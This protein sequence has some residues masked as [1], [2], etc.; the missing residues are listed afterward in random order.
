M[1]EITEAIKLFGGFVTKVSLNT[2]W[3][4]QSST[5]QISI[6]YEG[7]GP[8]NSNDFSKNF[9]EP[10]TCVG[11]SIGELKFAGIFQ[12]YTH[13]KDINGYTYNIVLESPAKVLDGVQLILDTFQNSGYLGQGNFNNQIKNVWNPFALLENLNYGGIFGGANVNSAG[14]PGYELFS[15]LGPISRNETRVGGKINYGENEY[16]LDVEEVLKVLTSIPNYHMYRIKGPIQSITSALDDFASL[17]MHD[18]IL[19]VEPKNGQITNGIIKDPVIKVMLIDR[20]KPKDGTAIKQIVQNY[21]KEGKLISADIGKELNDA[22]TQKLVLGGP[23]TRYYICYKDMLV[24]IWGRTKGISP[25]YVTSIVLDDGTLYPPDI[26]EVRCAMH[27]FDSWILFQVLRKYKK[28]S[29]PVVDRY[30]DALFTH[31]RLDEFSLGRIATGKFSAVDFIDS[32]LKSAEKRNLVTQGKFVY[33]ELQKIH[34]SIKAAGEEYWGR[35]FGIPLLKE[36]GGQ[37]N[38]V[39]FVTE[40]YQYINSWEVTDSAWWDHGIFVNDIT[41]YDGEG[42]LKSLSSWEFN[43]VDYDYTNLGNGYAFDRNNNIASVVSLEKDIIWD[44]GN[45]YC[46]AEVPAVSIYDQYTTDHNGLAWLLNMYFNYSFDSLS[47][48][49]TL[50]AESGSNLYGI[51]PARVTPNYIT[52]P[53]VSTRYRYGPWWN[54]KANNG[55]AEVVIEESLSPEV[56]GGVYNMNSVG[57]TYAVVINAEISGRETGS[58]QT[59]GLPESNIADYFL[60]AGPLV[61]G[62]D[63]DIGLEGLTTSYRFNTWTPE[64]G[65]LAKYNIDRLAN[66]NKSLFKFVQDRGSKKDI[67]RPFEIPKYKDQW[68][69]KRMRSTLTG[70]GGLNIITGQFFDGDDSKKRVVSTGGVI[71]NQVA[72]ISRNFD[73]VYGCSPEQ[74]FTPVK[75]K[76]EKKAIQSTSPEIQEKVTNSGNK[77]EPSSKTLDPYFNHKNDFTVAVHGEKKPED[78]NIQNQKTPPET[79][80]TMGLRAP[81]I[82]SG[83]GFGLDMKKAPYKKDKPTEYPD[84]I[85]E[86]RDLWKTGPVDLRWDEVRKVWSCGVDVIEGFLLTDVTPAQSF[87]K[88]TTFEVDIYRNYDKIDQNGKVSPVAERDIKSSGEKLTGVNR[89]TVLTL[90]AGTRVILMRI[91]YEWRIFDYSCA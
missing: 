19:K 41:F 83:W 42:K 73:N 74:I 4:S 66:F 45:P 3:G 44:N 22:V 76:K 5:A 7:D 31:V 38:N 26:M 68:L 49:F 72:N 84:D 12:R 56:F 54:S 59:P 24:Q 75:T 60:G 13:N 64:F 48:L 35:K 11:I 10:G 57:E 2:G 88:P 23:A 1:T 46:F 63:I 90:K 79:I 91:N 37:F 51:A 80:K 6:V 85:G 89:D 82:L 14:F 9:P 18:Y 39:K 87:K 81:L 53:Q 47:N 58:I 15:L 30:S 34:N 36:P 33:E 77:T 78:L 21:E 52:V 69:G 86:R 8:L 25:R 50:S 29:N 43:P 55:K 71:P 16:E 40:D 65:R 70:V 17:F 28:I 27:S 62:M 20:S 67:R 61:T 32:T